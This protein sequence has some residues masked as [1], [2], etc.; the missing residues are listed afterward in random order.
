MVLQGMWHVPMSQGTWH[1]MF[2]GVPA[3]RLIPLHLIFTPWTGRLYSQNTLLNL[4]TGHSPHSPIVTHSPSHCHSLTWS[5]LTNSLTVWTLLH[6]HWSP[7]HYSLTITGHL[8]LLSHTT[9]SLSLNTPLLTLLTLWSSSHCHWSRSH[10]HWSPSHCHGTV[11]GQPLTTLSLSMALLHCHCILFNCHWSH[12][13]Y[14]HH[15]LIITS[16][17]IIVIIIN[18]IIII[19]NI[20]IIIIN[21]IIIIINI[22]IINITITI[23]MNWLFSEPPIPQRSHLIIFF[24]AFFLL[25]SSSLFISDPTVPFPV[26]IIIIRRKDT[27]TQVYTL[28]HTYDVT[29]TCNVHYS[30][31]LFLSITLKKPIPYQ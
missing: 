1:W 30:I 9:L 21:I 31:Q 4:I 10:C 25:N 20:I 3:Q 6:W 15:S 14:P 26:N 8:T 12:S 23:I 19:I 2:P 24:Y 7:S 22:T 18:I 29:H 5:S 17:I 13:H 11:T 27:H 16:F 28:T